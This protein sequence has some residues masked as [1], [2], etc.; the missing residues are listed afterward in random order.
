MKFGLF[1]PSFNMCGGAEFVALV[2]ANTLARSGHEVTLLVNNPINQNLIIRLMGKALDPR[3][4]SVVMPSF[5]QPRGTFNLYQSAIRSQILKRITGLIVDTYSCAF[6]PWS[7]I[8]YIHF[9]IANS[10]IYR[11]VFPYLKEPR[12]KTAVNLPFTIYARM[13]QRYGKN[14]KMLIANSKYTEKAIRDFIGKSAKVIYP[15]VPSFFFDDDPRSLSNISSYKEDL[16]VTVSRFGPDKGLEKI[17]YVARL[18]EKRIKFVI[19]GLLHDS[20]TYETLKDQISKF[21]LNDRVKLIPNAP[22]NLVKNFLRRAKIYFHTMDGEHFGISIVEAMASGCIPIVPNSGGMKEFV[23]LEYRYFNIIDAVKKINL[24]L[25][26]Y[27]SSEALRMRKIADM[28]R[29][30]NFSHDFLLAINEYLSNCN[31]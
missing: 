6:F 12:L 31:K 3:I 8:V 10:N 19:I 27:S 30:E 20:K 18:S 22:R 28:F 26:V 21:D 15:P 14:E 4:T 29:E 2:A 16:V 5:L 25:S 24:G 1:H 9:P 7:D 17:P 13:L 23:P 11:K